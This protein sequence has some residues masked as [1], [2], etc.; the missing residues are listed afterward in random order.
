MQSAG[1]GTMPDFELLKELCR[2]HLSGNHC[3]HQVHDLLID[4]GY[5]N[6]ARVHLADGRCNGDDC[7]FFT[8]MARGYVNSP[9]YPLKLQWLDASNARTP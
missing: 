6:I 7:Q 3:R 8:W 2:A 9:D 4:M 1:V 5:P